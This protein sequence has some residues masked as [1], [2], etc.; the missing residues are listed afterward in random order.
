MPSVHVVLEAYQNL[1]LAAWCAGCVRKAY[2]EAKITVIADGDM[3]P[4]YGKL[5]SHKTRVIYGEQLWLAGRAGEL[6]ERRFR[7]FMED[8]ADHLFKIDTDT[9][10]YRPL[11]EIPDCRGLFGTLWEGE[12]GFIT[13]GFIGMGRDTAVE[14]FRSGL[15]NNETL[16]RFNVKDYDPKSGICAD[17]RALSY[18]AIQL[19][20]RLVDHPEISSRWRV[21]VD[22]SDLKYAV[23]HPCKDGQL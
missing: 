1:A 3:D 8:P 16:G 17:D 14:I 2:P 7:V 22:N 12:K 5:S 4:A 23:V 18:T 11:T 15:L 21:R 9:G 13:G 19:G 6:W 10:F 20:M